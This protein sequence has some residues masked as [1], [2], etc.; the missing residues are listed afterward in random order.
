MELKK[1]KNEQGFWK[2][3]HLHE[4]LGVRKL[5]MQTVFNQKKTAF[6]I[7]FSLFS[8]KSFGLLENQKMADTC[9]CVIYNDIV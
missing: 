6:F 3:V 7:R 8:F 5:L 9:C 4:E 1:I 2:C